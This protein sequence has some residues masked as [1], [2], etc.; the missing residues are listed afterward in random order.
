VV[1]WRGALAVVLEVS[2]AGVLIEQ[3]NGDLSWAAFSAATVA[4][5]Y[6]CVRRGFGEGRRIKRGGHQERFVIGSVAAFSRA[7]V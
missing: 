7:E 5:T 4:G 3:A 2:R 1:E 6:D